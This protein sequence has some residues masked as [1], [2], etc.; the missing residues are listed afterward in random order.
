MFEK[1][2][3]F[4]EEF[5]YIPEIAKYTIQAFTDMKEKCPICEE[6][7]LNGERYFRCMSCQEPFHHEHIVEKA[8]EDGHCPK[9]KK[10]ILAKKKWLLRKI[11]SKSSF[12][13]DLNYLLFL[14]TKEEIPIIPIMAS[15]LIPKLSSSVIIGTG[16]S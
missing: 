1:L 12:W 7:I 2:N 3:V 13:L 10:N 16:N 4:A 15:M 5:D 6:K 8:G 14:R 9:C 11:E